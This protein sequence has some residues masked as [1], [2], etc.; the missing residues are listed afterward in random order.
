M[1]KRAYMLGMYK[2]AQEAGVNLPPE[3]MADATIN[4]AF[5]KALYAG[6]GGLAGAAGGASL[7]ALLG[8]VGG[9][10]LREQLGLGM[11]DSAVLGALLGGGL[12]AGV[13][14]LTGTVKGLDEADAMRLA[15]AAN[16]AD[17]INRLEDEAR[18]SLYGN[19]YGEPKL[20]AAKKADW[21][22]F[23]SSGGLSIIDP[24]AKAKPLKQWPKE[25]PTNPT[26]ALAHRMESVEEELRKQRV[27]RTGEPR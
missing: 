8:G 2:A 12:G 5:R 23:L 16:Q 20:S 19:P 14:G 26:R 17:I 13:G 6:G 18:G 22:D 3:A 15:N 24:P 1:L 11:R 25:E 9:A 10:A 7:G 21:R 4:P 27:S